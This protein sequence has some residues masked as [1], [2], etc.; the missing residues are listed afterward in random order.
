M[1]NLGLQKGE[2]PKLLCIILF[3]EEMGIPG[4]GKPTMMR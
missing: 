2:I 4:S 1:G 3:N